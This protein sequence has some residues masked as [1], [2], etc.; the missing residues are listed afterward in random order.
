MMIEP[1]LFGLALI[2]YFIFWTKIWQPSFVD[3]TR[4][5]NYDLREE[6]RQYFIDRR[7]PLDHNIYKNV[8]DLL[9]KQVRY[10][11]DFRILDILS[12][13]VIENKELHKY[14]H[15]HMDNLF[16]GEDEELN[17]FIE[18]VRNKSAYIMIQ[19]MF[20]T[21]LLLLVLAGVI[22]CGFVVKNLAG[23]ISITFIALKQS[24]FKASDKITDHFIRDRRILE[25]VSFYSC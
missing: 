6:V 2:L 11:E 15:E 12:I 4:D 23:R 5:K 13:L 18:D 14:L 19:H 9:N 22:A 25:E 21:S 10:I 16:K 7:L 24:F 20:E 17:K 8:R 1:V 3:G